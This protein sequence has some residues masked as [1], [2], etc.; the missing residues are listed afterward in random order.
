LRNS[1]QW[2][3][4]KFVFR[5]GRLRAT[6]DKRE[7]LVSSRLITDLVARGYE[8][9]IARFATGRLLDLGCGKVPLYEAYKGRVASATC[10]DWANSLHRNQHLDFEC[11]LTQP[12]PFDD[13]QFETVILSDVLE[14]IPEPMNLCREIRRVLV[15]NGVIIMNVPFL[16]WLHETPHDYYRYTEFALRRFAELADLSVL[17]M[18]V[19]GGAPEVITDILA[20]TIVNTPAVGSA[21]AGALQWLTMSAVSLG[22]GRKLSTRTSSTFPL[23]Y[24]MVAKRTA[25]MAEIPAGRS[26]ESSMPGTP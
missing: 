20:K 4:S 6:R 13:E 18:R 22:P 1:D 2:K 9:Y 19:I 3:P 26:M 8:E 5:Y 16:Y 23:G 11:D 14:H 17:E 10:V 15:N 21:I 7:V 25:S 24:F 12:L